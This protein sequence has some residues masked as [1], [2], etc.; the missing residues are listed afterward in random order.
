M[1]TFYPDSGIDE[2][3]RERLMPVEGAIPHLPGIEMYG[4]S[5]P[6]GKVGGDLFEYIN[7]QQR[8]DIDARIERALK[9]S[10]EFLKPHLLGAPDWNSVDDQVEWLKSRQDYRVEMEGAYR[11]SRSLDQVRVAED[12]KDLFSTAGVLVVDAQ[13]HGVIAAKIASTVHDTF[14]ALML[15]KLDRYGKTAPELFEN[16]NLRLAHSVTARNA[17]GRSGKEEA[18]E[19]A[20]MLYGEVRSSGHFRFVNFGHPPPLVFSAQRNTFAEIDR[21]R[22]VQFFPLGL[23]IP[24]DH[25]DRKRYVSM[26]FRQG[27]ADYSDIADIALINPGDILFLYTDGVYDGGDEQGRRNLEELIRDHRSLSAKEICG[28]VM[29]YAVGNDRQLRGRGESDC[30]DDKTVF[31][32]KRSDTED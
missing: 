25:P 9:R 22:M 16:I 3:L 32:I 6:A 29:E 13:G 12:L 8:Y 1:A 24:E 11:E 15:S 19:I 17:L 30:V 31:I 14:H 20:T 27:P 23:E 5:I 7:F 2:Y 28:V 21:G 18:R 26:H 10:K 4:D